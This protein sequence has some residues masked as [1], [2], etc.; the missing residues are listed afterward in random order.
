MIHRFAVLFCAAGLLAGCASSSPTGAGDVT[1][2]AEIRS[3]TSFGFCVGYCQT[4][5]TITSREIVFV[6]EAPRDPLPP[7][8]RT[9]SISSSEWQALVAAV[10]RARLQAVPDVL[11]CPD[12]ADGGAES[13]VVVADGWSRRITFE[14]GANVPELEPLLSRVRALRERADP[15][16]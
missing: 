3:E 1:P 14:Y 5:T 9:L 8:R 2:V 4:S 6:E 10:D 15:E 12:C 13:L 16:A 7:R 11:G